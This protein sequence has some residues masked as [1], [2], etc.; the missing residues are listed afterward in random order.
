MKLQ[1]STVSLTCPVH[2]RHAAG[3]IELQAAR[4]VLRDALQHSLQPLSPLLLIRH[5]NV[6]NVPEQKVAASVLILISLTFRILSSFSYKNLYN[7]NSGF[8]RVQIYS[9]ILSIPV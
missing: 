8:S 6:K 2:I 9:R 3:D 4:P 1:K 5:K 7:G